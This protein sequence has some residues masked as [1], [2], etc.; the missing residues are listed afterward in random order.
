MHASRRA[1]AHLPAAIALVALLAGPNLSVAGSDST[2]EGQ[3][4]LAH[5][6]DFA[7]GRDTYEYRLQT[8]EGNFGL[9][10]DDDA[11][12]LHA[13][14]VTVSGQ[15]SGNTILA[16]AGGVKAAG[17][18]SATTPATGPKKVAIILFTFSDNSTEPYTPDY[19]GGV[20]FTNA[21]SVA[22]YYAETSWGQLSLSGDVFGWYALQ[23]RST[24]CAYSTW[25]SDA[26]AAAKAAGVDL[27]AYDYRVYA[28]PNV[29]ACGWAG[30]SYMPGTQSWL[31]GPNAMSLHVMAHELGHN[32]GTNHA[33]SYSCTES[34][35]RVSLSANTASC[36]STEYGDPFSVMGGATSKRQETNFSR[37]NLGWLSMA[38]TLDVTQSDTYK[39]DPVEP[40]DLTG[41]RAL[42]IKRDSST[43]FLLELRQPYGTYFDN[44]F[45]FEPVVNGITV[46]IVPSY[47]TV[48]QSQ[49]VDTTPATSSYNDAALVVGQ[50]LF[51]PLSKVSFTTVAVSSSGATVEVSFGSDSSP[52]STPSGLSASATDASHV[53]LSWSAS[54]DNVGV[55][56]YKVYRDGSYLTTTASTDYTDGGLTAGT[57]YSYYVTAVDAAGNESAASNTASATTPASSDTTPPSAPRNLTATQVRNRPRVALAWLASTDDVGVA[58]YQV[59]R[60]GSLVTTVPAS[61]LSYMDN[62]PPRGTDS[63]YVVAVDAAGNLSTPSNTVSATL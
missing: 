48:S 18:N 44:F 29:N 62:K 15:R 12:E 19:A 17:G 52:P 10:F 22:A 21:N 57:T 34:G 27:S 14:K 40:P 6:D 41:V 37:G 26:D 20:A 3:L 13:G 11:P 33:N 47:S 32:F 58:G 5:G 2:F 36:T 42:R 35:V 51:D 61:S 4:V 8:A 59:Y 1:L 28:F 56:G 45:A 23:D 60:N 55:A 53:S 16:A 49:L 54:T 50:S 25:A 43:Y 7:H 38:N 63:Y 30:L 46:R 9:R 39:L 31:N 24:T